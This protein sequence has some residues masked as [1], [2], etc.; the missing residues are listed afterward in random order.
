MRVKSR[1]MAI[2]SISAVALLATACGGSSDD[3]STSGGGAGGEIITCRSRG[4]GS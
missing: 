1:A 4:P 3:D 2:A